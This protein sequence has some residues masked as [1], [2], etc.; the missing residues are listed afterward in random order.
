L[1]RHELLCAARGPEARI[2]HKRFGSRG[3][4]ELLQPAQSP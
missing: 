3:F 1:N 4:V 2:L